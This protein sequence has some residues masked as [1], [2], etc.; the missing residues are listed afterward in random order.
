MLLQIDH[1]MNHNFSIDANIARSGYRS[2]RP[3]RNYVNEKSSPC[4]WKSDM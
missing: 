4:V 3:E 1:K 2:S